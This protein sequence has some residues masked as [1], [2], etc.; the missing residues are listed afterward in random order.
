M[1]RTLG[2][3]VDFQGAYKKMADE[4][5]TTTTALTQAQKMQA[6]TNE[7]LSQGANIAGTYEA[8]MGSA[9][10][11]L[12]SM[13]RHIEELQNE[14]G[15]TLLPLMG[16][17]VGAT[18]DFLKTLR[19]M[20]PV[21]K[22]SVVEFAALA[23]GILLVG[24]ALT[25]MA[26]GIVAVA[27][28]LGGAAL[29]LIAVTALVAGLAALVI[30]LRNVEKASQETA[31]GI[32]ADANSFAEYSWKIEAAG[33]EARALTEELYDLA[34]AVEESGSAFNRL[35]FQQAT[36]DLKAFSE[37]SAS[38][39]QTLMELPDAYLSDAEAIEG[40]RAAQTLMIKD[41]N[42][43]ELRILANTDAVYRWAVASGVGEGAA[44]TWAEGLRDLAQV[45][46]MYNFILGSGSKHVSR[47]EAE[48]QKASATTDASAFYSERAREAAHKLAAEITVLAE[49]AGLTE[50]KVRELKVELGYTDDEIKAFADDIHLTGKE[51][52]DLATKTG[53]SKDRLKEL[54]RTMGQKEIED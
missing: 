47:W 27:T 16:Q 54:N 51:L 1:A 8:A 31:A 53:L 3:T 35:E 14:L 30:H 20:D 22:T 24:G 52:D 17:I 15:S 39:F 9:G 32:L 48:I 34:K 42:D 38:H 33:E 18:T 46:Q 21:L 43:S 40:F 29:P 19:E 12:R 41:M 25:A 4:L 36:K 49:E 44:R 10:K 45:Q 23:S 28:V 50:A 26:P 7:V 5:G 13:S 11:Q 2:L 37:E 6:R